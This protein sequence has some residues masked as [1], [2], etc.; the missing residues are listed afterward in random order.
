MFPASPPHPLQD[1][2]HNTAGE[3][4]ERCQGGFLGNSSLDGQA[5]S[6]SSC[7]CPLRVPSNKSVP[8]PPG[9]TLCSPPTDPTPLDNLLPVCVFARSFAEGCVQ[10][11]DR[12][13]CLCMPGYAG[14]NCER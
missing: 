2:Q 3:H 10:R 14:P 7:P 6:C 11:S 13:Q 1:C 9:L 5:A 4:C 12:M 8:P